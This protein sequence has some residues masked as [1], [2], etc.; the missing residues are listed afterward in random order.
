VAPYVKRTPKDDIFKRSALRLV[1]H[2]GEGRRRIPECAHQN[3]SRRWASDTAQ[4]SITDLSADRVRPSRQRRPCREPRRGRLSVCPVSW[5]P[6][7]ARRSVPRSPPRC[8]DLVTKRGAIFA[9]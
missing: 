9:L 7:A 4:A 6:G 8:R 5:R 3:H 2:R 1:R